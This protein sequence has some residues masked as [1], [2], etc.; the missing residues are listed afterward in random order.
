MIIQEYLPPC[1]FPSQSCH[2]STIKT[3]ELAPSFLGIKSQL[4]PSDFNFSFRAYKNVPFFP[5]FG[6]EFSKQ[7]CMDDILRNR[8]VCIKT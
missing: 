7:I 4:V 2:H 3:L 1:S 6:P 8:I 5:F